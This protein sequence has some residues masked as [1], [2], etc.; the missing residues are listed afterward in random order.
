MAAQFQN[1]DL[2]KA[3]LEGFAILDDIRGRRAKI[4]PPPTPTPIPIPTPH[5][6][7]QYEYYD[8]Q[9]S[10][11]VYRSLRTVTVIREPVIDSYQAAQ[12]YGGTGTIEYAQFQ[13][14]DLLKAGLE[15]F[16]I[17]DDIRGRRA[18]ISPPPPTPTP[19]PVPIPSPHFHHQYKYY[20]QQQSYY[21][22]RNLR[23]VTVIREPVIDS[24]QAAQLYG[25]IGTIEYVKDTCTN[26]TVTGIW[27]DRNDNSHRKSTVRSGET[28]DGEKRG[29]RKKNMILAKK[30][31]FV[32]N[33]MCQSFNGTDAPPS[34]SSLPE[35]DTEIK[36]TMRNLV[37]SLKI[38]RTF[39]VARYSNTDHKCSREGYV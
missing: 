17:L 4:S 23:V 15:G 13:N 39:Y 1:Q 33:A 26:I 18:K 10:Y 32:V 30:E 6:H 3:G 28:V 35:A 29:R 8:Q 9:Q 11:Y 38:E 2:L 20:D 36:N 27:L 19:I 7:H 12:M 14:Q 5:F 25:G 22:C 31:R 37:I 16:A 24:Y 34:D 21:V